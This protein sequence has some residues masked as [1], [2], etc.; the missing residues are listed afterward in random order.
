MARVSRKS[1]REALKA[2]GGIVAQVAESFDVSRQTVY[3][4]I[5]EYGLRD[6]ME[7]ARDT[8]FD[9]AERNVYLAVQ[10]GDLDMSK[11]VLTHMPSSTRWSNR[12]ELTGANGSPLGLPADVIELMRKLNIQPEDLA[13]HLSE[14][15]RAEAAEKGASL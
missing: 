4:W 8:M 1:V 3:N 11:F 7:F 5:K 9:I 6:E 13:V 10:A 15:V 12:Q 14:L 2:H